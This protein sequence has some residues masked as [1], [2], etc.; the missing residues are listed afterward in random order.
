MTPGE[1]HIAR[2]PYGDKGGHKMRPVL[3]LTGSIGQVPEVVTAYLSSQIPH[4][5]LP[6]DI[7]ID[8][9]Q[10]D[11][12]GT[13]LTLTS[14]IRLHKLSTVHLKN[15]VRLVGSVSAATW[16]DVQSRLRTLLNL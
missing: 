3:L 12:A 7:V 14:V 5:L 16:S 6:S 10:P 1:I 4:P 13:H 15:V 2:F 11:H 9:K 8:P